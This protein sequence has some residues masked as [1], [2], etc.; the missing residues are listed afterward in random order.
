MEAAPALDPDVVWAVDHHL[1]DRVVGKRAL[2]R[3]V[4][5]D[6]VCDLLGETFTVLAGDAGLLLE[7][8]AD[9]GRDPGAHRGRVGVRGEELRTELA[10][11][12]EMD[13]VLDLVEAVAGG[14]VRAIRAESLL[15][16]Q[17]LYLRPIASRR[18]RPFEDA[19]PFSLCP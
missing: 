17:G 7:P 3:A 12:G 16:V 2:E 1:G 8:A 9:V 10:D 5:E 4:A 14:A 15:E 11:H 19:L 13:P 6:V 18:R